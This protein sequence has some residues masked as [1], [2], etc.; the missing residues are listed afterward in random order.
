MESKRI[1]TDARQMEGVPC[2]RGLPIAVATIA[3][4]LMVNY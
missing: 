4:S 2:L 3:P 1:T